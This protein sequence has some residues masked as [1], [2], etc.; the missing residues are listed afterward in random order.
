MYAFNLGLLAKQGW[1]LVNDSSSLVAQTL[2]AKYFPTVSF[3]EAK[4]KSN[5]LPCWRSICAAR[6]VIEM[7]S[8]WQIG[9]GDFAKIWDNHWIPYPSRFRLFSPKPSHYGSLFTDV[10]FNAIVSMP[11]SLQRP[12]DKLIWHYDKEVD[13]R[14]NSYT[15]LWKK[16]WA[17][18]V[19]PFKVKVGVW[20]ICHDI[21]PNRL[22]LIKRHVAIDSHCVL[23][24]GMVEST[25][26]LMRDC[27]YASCAWL[28]TC[29]GKPPTGNTGNTV[30]DWALFLASHLGL[31]R[32]E[33][34]LMV[35]FVGICPSCGG[36][37]QPIGFLKINVDGTWSETQMVGGIGVVIRDED[38]G[39]VAAC[40]KTFEYVS[41][42]IHIEALVAREWLQLAKL[43]GLQNFILKS[44]SLQITSAL[45]SI[46][47]DMSF[48]GHIVEDSKAMLTEIIGASIA[49]AYC[50]RNEAAHCL[51]R[52]ALSSSCDRAWF[53]EPPDIIL[54][55]LLSES[56]N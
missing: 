2:K 22:N 46:F 35:W 45:N 11:L 54:D 49:H 25:L 50:Q 52:S 3:F 38:E 32:F 31:S 37:K 26:H 14:T 36:S 8:R 48:I 33:L 10:E 43:R 5:A 19:P 55:V 17:A 39:F 41:S 40:V 42:P 56:S 23:C 9:T 20:K 27:Y 16:I 28:S 7:G 1:G 29:I 4:V 15:G 30:K 13:S 12:T 34:C 53:E 47:L 24:K 21:I 18:K 44:D 6:T 51:A